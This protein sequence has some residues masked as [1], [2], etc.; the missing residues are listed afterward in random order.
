M[1]SLAELTPAER[2]RLASKPDGELG[3][4]TAVFMNRNN[5]GII[6]AVY[7]RLRAETGN[8]VLEIGFGNGRT[9]PSLM[10]Q[11]AALT[12]VGIDISETM[13]AEAKAFN[14]SLIDAGR[15][16]FHLASAEAIPC[17]DASFDRAMAINVV[18]FWLDPVRVLAEIRRV[19][20]PSGFSI[21]AG[22]DT[23]TAAVAP[24]TRVEFGF[25]ARDAELLTALHHQAGFTAVNVEP[26]AEIAKHPDG[27]PFPRH[28]NLVI[29]QY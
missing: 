28:Y 15:A 3:I 27:T 29:A 21:I 4:E 6:D 8:T 25:R 23:A 17:D 12:Y 22:I 16:S 19:L 1:P 7:R 5:A 2:A 18:Y 10:Q 26:Y 11:A 13:V 20:R 24:F 9:L 14:K